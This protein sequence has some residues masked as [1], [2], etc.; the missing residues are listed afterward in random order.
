[1]EVRPFR[2]DDDI[3]AELDLSRRAF[4]PI[5]AGHRAAWVAGIEGSIAAGAL[6]GAFDGGRL[7]GSARY[8]IMRQWWQGRSL[9]MAG[10]AGVKVAPEERG[11]GVGTAMMAALLD[12]I[13][14][15]GYPLS[16]LF[17][18]T[19][20]LYRALGWEIAG[21][22]YEIVLP[23]TSLAGLVR[24][25]RAEPATTDPPKLRRATPADGAAIVDVKGLV[26]E[27]MLHCGPNTREPWVL[28]DWLDDEDHFAYLADDG[29]LS[30]RWSDDR[31]E[32]DVEELT[33][34]SASTARAFWR[35]LAS[36]AT[37]VSRVRAC[38]AP[39]DPVTWLTRD[40]AAELCQADLWMLRVVDAPAAIAGRGYPVAATVTVAL[41]IADAAQPANS[42]HWQLTVSGGAGSLTRLGDAPSGPRPP[43]PDSLVPDSAVL[44]VGP[45]GLA[46]L[47]AGVPVPTLRQ[48]GLL[49][50][51]DGMADDALS[52]AFCGPAFAIDRY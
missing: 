11:R 43:V 1:M 44:G 51:G 24:P 4:G 13:A 31:E 3:E 50:G 32:L 33:A 46:A 2:P 27:R 34:A 14:D 15:R 41:D 38:L 16:V 30:Y 35:I 52:A 10:V 47:Y 22:R 48:A 12:D 49:S 28:R 42:G 7:V 40:P 5:R 18:S 6:L 19:A 36:H 23:A 37:M 45:R 21:R 39:D 25:D 26:H 29:F 9:P 8:H 20:P 17:P